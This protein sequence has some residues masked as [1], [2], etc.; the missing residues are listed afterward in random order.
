MGRPVH[1][2]LRQELIID[3]RLQFSHLVFPEIFFDPDFTETQK[4]IYMLS[5]GIPEIGVQ[6]DFLVP[7]GKKLF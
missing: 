2:I 4:F 5:S 3:D 7:H 1:K 6:N